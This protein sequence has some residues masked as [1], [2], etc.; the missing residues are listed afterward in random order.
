MTATLPRILVA[1]VAGLVALVAGWMV[2]QLGDG[3]AVAQRLPIFTCHDTSFGTPNPQVPVQLT[4]QFG[5]EQVTVMMSKLLC[6]PLI[7]P[8]SRDVEPQP[9]TKGDHLLCYRTTRLSPGGN[10][11]LTDQFGAWPRVFIQ[12]YGLL[13]E[14]ADKNEV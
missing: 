14:P 3:G 2:G 5:L 7:E 10:H 6:T 8:K 9:V 13:C 12:D 1:L 4:D 11:A